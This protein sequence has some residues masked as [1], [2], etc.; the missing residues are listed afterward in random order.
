MTRAQ[1]CLAAFAIVLALVTLFMI[2]VD[3]TT[4]RK[5]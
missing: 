2:A 5:R 1:A 4:R 3:P